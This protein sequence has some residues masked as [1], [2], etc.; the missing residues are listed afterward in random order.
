MFYLIKEAIEE[1]KMLLL[2]LKLCCHILLWW[3]DIY[4]C[5]NSISL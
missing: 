5:A 3:T 4:N 1:K 2:P